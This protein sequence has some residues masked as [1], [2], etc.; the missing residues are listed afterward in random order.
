MAPPRIFMRLIAII[1]K[2]YEISIILAAVYRRQTET[3]GAL[4][5][6]LPLR[7]NDMYPPS[8]VISEFKS[9]PYLSTLQYLN[10]ALVQLHQLKII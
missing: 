1:F 6:V 10:N 2:V 4:L 5:L 7:M 3:T 9:I 8:E